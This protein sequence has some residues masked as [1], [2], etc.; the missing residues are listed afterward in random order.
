MKTQK[1]VFLWIFSLFAL[2]VIAS[3]GV[4]RAQQAN[5]V[6]YKG[7]PVV[8]SDLDGLTDE[9]ERQMYKTDPQN[10]DTDGDGYYDGLELT[11]NA[12]PA[13]PQDLPVNVKQELIDKA[14]LQLKAENAAMADAETPWPWYISRVS[15][16]VAFALLYISILL[17]LV[18]R[19]RFLHRLFAPLYAMNAHCWLALQATIIALVHGL[20]L[21]FDKFLKFSLL[22]VLVPFT[23]TYEPLLVALGTI[24]FYLMVIL[25]TTSYARRHMSQKVWRALHFLNIGLYIIV[26]IHALLLGTDLKDPL[27]RDIFV[28]ANEFLVLLMFINM[29]WRIRDAWV[30][31][32]IVTTEN[33]ENINTSKHL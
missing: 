12:N 24:G 22:G 4:A 6:D 14:A 25:T 20:A 27:F 13:D 21:V 28:A 3:L 7:Q 8:D 23:S 11:N 33:A 5:Q 1:K 19:I 16:L 26:V 18:L 2:V 29:F 15:G 30:R 17:G 31:R 10:P 9:G 32:R